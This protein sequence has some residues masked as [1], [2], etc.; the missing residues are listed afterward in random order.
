MERGSCRRTATGFTTLDMGNGPT[1]RGANVLLST[2]R[3]RSLVESQTFCP[4]WYAGAGVRRRLAA[5]ACSRLSSGFSP[6][7]LA[8]HG[9]SIS[10]WDLGFPFLEGGYRK[11]YTNKIN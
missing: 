10:R 8:P 2:P 3:G 1:K 6:Y 5:L 7:A 11:G 9:R 4:T